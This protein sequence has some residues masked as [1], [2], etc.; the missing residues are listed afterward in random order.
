MLQVWKLFRELHGSDC[1][2]PFLSMTATGHK[3]VRIFDAK[4]LGDMFAAILGNGLNVC[5]REPC[6]AFTFSLDTNFEF[7]VVAVME[8]DGFVEDLPTRG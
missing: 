4:Y 5:S 2:R 3:S 8:A 7:E 1:E 6:L